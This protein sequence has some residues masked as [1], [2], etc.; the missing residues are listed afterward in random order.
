MIQLAFEPAFDP[1]HAAFRLLRQVEFRGG[2]AVD[3]RRA[4]ILDVYMVEPVRCLEIR[5]SGVA[6][7][8]A[9]YASVHQPATYGQRPST[10]VLFGRMSPMQDAAIQTLVL[11]GILDGDAYGQGLLL[12]GDTPLPE[13]LTVRLSEVNSTQATLMTFLGPVLDEV[14]LDGPNGLKARTGLGEFRYDI[15]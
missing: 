6:K 8:S 4:K 13:N 3:V 2:V 7:R 11:Q 5:L 1:F 14:P 15:V 9:K 12:R 10:P